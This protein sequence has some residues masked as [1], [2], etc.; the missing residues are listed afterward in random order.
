M[1]VS[2]FICPICQSPL[3]PA[4]DTWRCDG[5]LNPKN[6]SHPFDVARQGYVNLLPVNQK[7]SKSPGDSSN[8][9]LARQRFLAN[10]H[11]QPLRDLVCAQ[12]NALLSAKHSTG[13]TDK[14]SVDWLDIGCGEGYYTGAIAQ[15]KGINSLIA[16]DISKPA[17]IEVAKASKAAKRLWLDIDKQDDNK[18]AIYPIVTSAA[19]LP[20]SANSL[21]GITSI[22]SPILPTAFA[23]VLQEGGYLVIAKPDIG[24]LTSVREALFDEVR[25]HNSDKFLTELAPFF[26]VLDTQ[27]IS[28]E[29]TLPAAD[30]ADLLTMTPYAYRAQPEKRQ[31]L[32]AK[33]AAASFNTEA[34]FVVYV[35]K[36]RPL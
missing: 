16:A 14:S 23:D 6:V 31:A 27:R 36:K 5:S 21:T 26:E 2:L 9:I 29:L 7:K 22:F 4:A 33:A 24:H 34:K 32:L 11:Y 28:A 18:E 12:I 25:E 1:L 19:H 30:L 17:V 8:S 15:T 20:L 35:L 13:Q 3:F 10:A